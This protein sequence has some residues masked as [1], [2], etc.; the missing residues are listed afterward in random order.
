MVPDWMCGQM[1]TYYRSNY[2]RMLGN[3]LARSAWPTTQPALWERRGTLG[4][5][6]RELP[7]NG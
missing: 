2:V 6:L 4:T 7:G 1:L 5:S 3:T